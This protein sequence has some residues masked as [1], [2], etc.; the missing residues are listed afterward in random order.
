M[1]IDNQAILYCKTSMPQ[2]SRL[3]VGPAFNNLYGRT[4]NP[5][6]VGHTRANAGLRAAGRGSRYATTDHDRP[7]SNLE[8]APPAKES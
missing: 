1:D 2:A 6:K 5:F 8:V 4:L 7:A 3:F